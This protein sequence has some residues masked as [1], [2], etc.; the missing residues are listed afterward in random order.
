MKLAEDRLE[1]IRARAAAASP[2]PWTW[3]RD[4]WL[5]VYLELEAPTGLVIEP[6]LWDDGYKGFGLSPADAEFLE[7]ARQDVDDLL[8]E[9][10]RLRAAL[11][12]YANPEHWSDTDYAYFATGKSLYEDDEEEL[13]VCLGRVCV[14]KCESDGPTLAQEALKGGE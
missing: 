12:E 13:E 14:W 4:P 7:Y 5:D 6:T 11:E 1:E 9:I 10:E 8:G 2:P 3:R